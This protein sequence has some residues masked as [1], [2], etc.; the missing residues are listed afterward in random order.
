MLKISTN[1]T[2]CLTCNGDEN[3]DGKSDVLTDS[4]HSVINLQGE[5]LERMTAFTNLGSTLAED[6]YLNAEII[7]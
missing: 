1:N 6:G 3:S 7:Q 2:A 4:H 5:D